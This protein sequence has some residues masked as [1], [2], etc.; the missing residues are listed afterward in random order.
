MTASSLPA[1]ATAGA[2]TRLTRWLAWAL[3]AAA[4]TS[5]CG[6]A[7]GGNSLGGAPTGTGGATLSTPSIT[8]TPATATAS[9]GATAIS[10]SAALQSGAS[11]GF[12]W[13]VNGVPGGDATVGTISASGQYLSPAVMPSPSTVT[14]LAVSA[15]D[16]SQVGTAEVTLLAGPAIAVSV[17]PSS[18][19]VV[20]GGGSQIFAASVSGTANTAVTWQ[21]NGVVGGDATVGTIGVDGLYTA[22]ATPPA[23]ATVTISAVSVADP[24]R[25]A[26]AAV[27]ISA[28][29]ATVRVTI[30]P[31]AATVVIGTGTQGFAATV[32]NGSTSAVTWQ[33]NGVT[34]GN[35][36]TGTITDTG[37]YSAPVAGTA[38]TTVTVTAVSVADPAQRAAAVVTLTAPSAVTLT[39]SGADVQAGIGSQSFTASVSNATSPA[40]IWQVNG[41]TGGDATVGTI[42]QSGV[43]AAPAD[44]PASGTVTV[45]AALKT[46]PSTSGT[47]KV[48]VKARIKVAVSPAT[49]TATAGIGTQTFVATVSNTST[50]TVTWQVNGITGGNS[51]LGTITSAGVYSAPAAVPSPASVTVSAASVVDPARP[52]SASMTVTAP[53]SVTVSPATASVQVGV[54][55]Q[56]MSVAVANTSNT[57]VTWQV[58]GIAGGN[59]TLGT[60]S[61]VGVYTAPATVPSPAA[62]TVTAVAV[63]DP[64]R[65]GSATL[66]LTPAIG[67]SVTPATVSVQAGIGSQ[68]FTA[69][70][71]NS[72]NSAVTWQVN[73][74]AGGNATVGTISAAGVYRSPAAVPSPAAVTITAVSVAD[75]LRSGSAVATVTAAV[76]VAISPSIASVSANTGR[77][78][79]TAAVSNGSSGAVSWQVNGTSGGNSTVGT[80]SAA[81]LYS[82][83]ATA[84]SP[85]TVAVT[86][87]SVDDPSKSASASVS[88]IAATVAPTISG[89]PATTASVGSAYAFQPSATGGSGATLTFS[90]ANAPAWASFSSAT[91]LLSG[92]PAA[93]A[94]GSYANISISVSDGTSSATLA[95][96]T[97]TV[98]GGAT[99]TA[100]VSWTVPTTRTDGTALTNL[101]G[102]RVYYGS[103]PGVYPT[104][105]NVTSP[106][107]TSYVVANLASGTYYFAATAYDSNGIESA[108]SAPGSKTIP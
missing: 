9:V 41:V 105:V 39:P 28:A 54:G 89:T 88:V 5:G 68:S 67:V 12:V 87:V 44:A 97:I 52:G 100:T 83:P 58:N 64:T 99:G 106:A 59:A 70:L 50:T 26:S 104:V 86:A 55:T 35:G 19:T 2:A 23:Q 90:I 46:A 108:Y 47:A 94:I 78:Q 73:G 75:P 17:S 29:A 4:L 40:L 76:A 45:S 14:V 69:T 56:A 24:T 43:Y 79:F 22:P 31:S 98:A 15:S 62:V 7:G 36:T 11:S 71:T 60:I 25:S 20:A 30:T 8:V 61:T 38:P 48:T 72:A 91:G 10:F 101:A 49:A 27:Q 63:A 93:G 1:P 53:V 21:V 96:F 6:G 74:V 103:S 18:A 66:T 82:A 92:T 3:V 57:A 37:L 102:F 32:V 95:P 34:G 42:T 81:G 77:Q 80:I 51:S 85:A 107:T 84:P 16:A 33:V 65:S 13:Q